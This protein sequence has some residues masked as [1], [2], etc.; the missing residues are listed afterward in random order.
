MVLTESV[1][2]ATTATTRLV[3][4][5][6]DILSTGMT[7]GEAVDGGIGGL[8]RAEEGRRGGAKAGGRLVKGTAGTAGR[9][10]GRCGGDW[11]GRT[12][13]GVGPL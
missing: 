4:P 5:V 12:G 7:G 2:D 8:W 9:A 3:Q 6:V 13:G 10:A 11:G 1:S